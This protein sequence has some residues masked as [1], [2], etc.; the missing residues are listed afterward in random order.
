MNS[1]FSKHAARWTY[2]EM[3]SP[4]PHPLSERGPITF[5]QGL[6]FDVILHV[7]QWRVRAWSEVGG[8]CGQES[9]L[10]VAPVVKRA[11]VTYRMCR[12]LMSK[13][14]RWASEKTKNKKKYVAFVANNGSNP[15]GELLLK[16][17]IVK[18]KHKSDLQCN[19]NIYIIIVF[20]LKAVL[21]LFL[22]LPV[23]ATANY[24][25]INVK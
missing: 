1:I 19:R 10:A 16:K 18:L 22:I 25:F 5:S 11:E 7:D 14:L 20:L 23:H 12:I 6:F 21:F 24:C 15:S 3:P 17:T 9:I 4:K 8:L 13:H 2:L